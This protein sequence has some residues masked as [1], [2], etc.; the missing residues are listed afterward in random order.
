MSIVQLNCAEYNDST[1]DFWCEPNEWSALSLR[2][3]SLHY[4]RT[5]L[6]SY[7]QGGVEMMCGV[8]LP[9]FWRVEL[10][11]SS[12]ITSWLKWC[13]GKAMDSLMESTQWLESCRT[14]SFDIGGLLFE[15]WVWRLNVFGVQESVTAITWHI[16]CR[17]CLW[18][19]L[20]L[21]SAINIYTTCLVMCS[22]FLIRVA[23]NKIVKFRS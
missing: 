9:F 17:Q 10:V 13:T 14:P 8:S 21:F 6:C 18:G 11:S 20:Q 23:R 22:M 19:R 16:F 4:M 1:W 5:E 2:A 15:Y 7:Q 3:V 12:Q